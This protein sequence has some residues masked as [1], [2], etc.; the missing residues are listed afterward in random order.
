MGLVI[1]ICSSVSVIE[2][3][4]WV[5]YLPSMSVPLCM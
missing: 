5:S 4:N 3:R 2:I 1:V